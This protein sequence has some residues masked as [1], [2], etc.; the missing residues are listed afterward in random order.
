MNLKESY[1]KS[2]IEDLAIRIKNQFSDFNQDEF[3]SSILNNGID[4]K[5]LKERMRLITQTLNEFLPFSFPKQIE[6]LKTVAPH[7][8]GIQGFVFSDFV[9]TFG[10]DDFKVSIR[11]LEVFTQYSTAEFAIRPFFLK[12]PEQTLQQM[13]TWSQHH[14]YHVRR[15]SSE[16]ARPKLPWSFPLKMFITDPIPV[17]PIL[18]NLKNDESEYVRKSVANHLNDISK[19]HPH[20]VLELAQK[21]YGKTNQTNRVVK[22]GLRTLLK[23]GDKK[24]LAIFNFDD[25]SNLSINGLNLLQNK[26][27]IGDDLLFEFDVLNDSINSRNVRLEYKID[28]VKSNG[29][30]SS[31]VFHITELELKKSQNKKFKKKQSFKN[32]T[33]RKHYPGKHF[34][35]ILANGEVKA[36][37]EFTLQS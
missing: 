11:A 30:L 24:A 2:F 18:E 34:I 19:T 23:E 28:Y 36:K 1:N 21:W 7:F 6:V 14:N 33:T 26:I 32:M 13:I 16:G 35:S 10:I 12:Y 29:S 15:L 9:E 25:T 31:K 4:E 5:E 27:T 3:I 8:G 20:L 22:H 17:I 37:K